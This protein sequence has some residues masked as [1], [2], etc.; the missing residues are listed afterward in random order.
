MNIQEKKRLF[1][2]RHHYS[3]LSIHAALFDMDGVLFDSMP[4]HAKAWVKAL[5]D[6]GIPF[7]ERDVYLNEG[8][9]GWDTVQKAYHRLY[10]GEC[11]SETVDKIYATKSRVFETLPPAQPMPGAYAL[12]QELQRYNIHSTVVTGSGE[13]TT[14]NK[15]ENTFPG[16]FDPKKIV[17]AYNVEKGKPYPDPYLKGLE[18]LD[19]AASD[20]IVIENAPLGIQSAVAAGIFSIAINTGPLPDNDLS[21]AGAELI[22]HSMDE[23]QSDLPL[24]ISR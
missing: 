24:I 13:L 2:E 14:I 3:Q 9:R 11:S 17:T 12:L 1:A 22:Y 21:E 6:F 23:L 4:M 10:G 7:T 16:I 8:S 18:M 20:A 19:V 15:I 5:N